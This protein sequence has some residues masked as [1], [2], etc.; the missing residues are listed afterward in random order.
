MPFRD[1][2]AKA[3]S[4]ADAEQTLGDYFVEHSPSLEE[5][6]T[7]AVDA[8]LR[9]QVADPLPVIIKNLQEIVQRRQGTK[10]PEEQTSVAEGEHLWTASKWLHSSKDLSNCIASSL[11][12]VAQ[13]H[14]ELEA[15]AAL[16]N[17]SDEVVVSRLRDRLSASVET[18]AELLLPKLR[19]LAEAEAAGA[20]TGM[21]LQ[22]K[23]ADAGAYTLKHLGLSAFFAGLEGLIGA[24]SPGTVADVIDAMRGEHTVGVTDGEEPNEL[25]LT[26]NYA[27]STTSAIEWSFVAEPA[28]VPAGG[29]PAESKNH[30]I[31]EGKGTR[32]IGRSPIPLETLLEAMRQKNAQLEAVGEPPLLDAEVISGR[33]YTGPLFFKYNIVLRGLDSPVALLRNGLVRLCCPRRVFEAYIG[34]RAEALWQPADGKLSY[35][36]ASVS[37]NKYT[38]TIH[39]INSCIV[40]VGKLT[41]AC[42]VYRGVSGGVLPDEFWNPDAF[43]L[44]GGVE[45]GFMST[46]Q[47]RDVAMNYA[48]NRPGKG[49]VVLEIEQGMT[50]RGADIGWLSQYPYEREILFGPLTGLETLDTRAEGAM[51]VVRLKSSVN[52]TSPTLERVIGKMKDAHLSLLKVLKTKCNN[53]DR[54]C[55][56]PGGRSTACVRDM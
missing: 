37:L 51:L 44:R 45:P 2:R 49:S 12:G 5:H 23:F 28:A 16:A 36:Q 31:S 6:L 11:L 17:G 25:F 46:T 18:M 40:K 34:S 10:E 47:S 41:Q 42:I 48:G 9:V 21:S 35:E 15:I 14:G 56:R 7:A 52:L 30:I 50:S 54:R 55:S 13:G 33:L 29:W 19:A 38:T 4:G 3:N 24:P 8:A 22:S 20:A 39:S 53:T 27:M 1:L 43:N 32:D 26:D